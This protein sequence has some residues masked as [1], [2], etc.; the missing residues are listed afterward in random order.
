MKEA[1]PPAPHEASHPSPSRQAGG[2]HRPPQG[3]DITSVES[4]V[5]ATTSEA[6]ASAEAELPEAEAPVAPDITQEPVGSTCRSGD[7]NDYINLSSDEESDIEMKVPSDN[8]I[9]EPVIENLGS[10]IN[11]ADYASV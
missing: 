5:P 6:S 3:Q 8:P 7:I 11:S 9:R 1:A 4:A 10:Q 2:A